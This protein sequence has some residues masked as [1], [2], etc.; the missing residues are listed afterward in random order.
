M[1]Q[2][3]RGLMRQVTFPKRF[4][5]YKIVHN[6]K[7]KR[8]LFLEVT[9]WAGLTVSERLFTWYIK[10]QSTK[11]KKNLDFLMLYEFIQHV[12]VTWKT[13]ITNLP[14][15]KKDL[16][17]TKL[18]HS[19]YISCSVFQP[20]PLI[21]YTSLF[22]IPVPMLNLGRKKHRIFIGYLCLSI[23]VKNIFTN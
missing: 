12:E 21:S 5:S 6:R 18:P 19:S 20:L 23:C 17:L 3:K 7:T 4:N 8:W 10:T 22:C 9:T 15:P 13:S 1:G 2:R 16:S 11:N 14:P